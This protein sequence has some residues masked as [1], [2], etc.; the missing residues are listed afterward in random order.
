MKTNQT[1]F[2]KKLS[3]KKSFKLAEQVCE[4]VVDSSQR[5]NKREQTAETATLIQVC[6]FLSNYPFRCKP[7][8]GQKKEVYDISLK[9]SNPDPSVPISFARDEKG[10]IASSFEP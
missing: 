4:V 10:S 7:A 3:M 8:N 9:I 1:Y 2:F 5:S 6:Q